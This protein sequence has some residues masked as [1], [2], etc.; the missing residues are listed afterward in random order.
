MM[1]APRVEKPCD[2]DW[3]TMTVGPPSFPGPRGGDARGRF[4]QACQ[5]SVIDLSGQTE[6]QVEKFVEAFERSGESSLCVR[7]AVGEDGDIEYARPA[8]LLPAS[9]LARAR[10]ALATAALP[11]AVAACN[12]PEDPPGRVP[13]F[14]AQ[15]LPQGSPEPAK[16]S[17]APVPTWTLE[18]TADQATS[19]TAG[20]IGTAARPAACEDGSHPT[21]AGVGC[22]A[23]AV[24]ASSSTALAPPPSPTD[25]SRLPRKPVRHKM[26][27]MRPRR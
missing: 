11:I 22:D 21:D 25:H 20:A 10:R 18:P 3:D 23:R 9:M 14:T 12:T 2:A 26:G 24:P 6:R 19:A 17:P 7:F 16:N 5:R 13:S 8:P 4:C 27:L 15:R 1:N